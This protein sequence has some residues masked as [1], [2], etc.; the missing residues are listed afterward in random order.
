M[1]R[2]CPRSPRLQLLAG[3]QPVTFDQ[4]PTGSVAGDC[5]DLSDYFADNTD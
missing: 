2:D 4:R 1:D 3:K 5:E